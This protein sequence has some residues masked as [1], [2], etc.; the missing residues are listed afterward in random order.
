MSRTTRLLSGAVVGYL[1]QAVAILVGLWLPA[2]MLHH[3]GREAYGSWVIVAKAMG[4]LALLDIGV[5]AIFPRDLAIAVGESRTQERLDPIH[6]IVG[7]TA[8]VVALQTPIVAMGA[9]VAWFYVR[10]SAPQL[11]APYAGM[12]VVM[13]MTFPLRMST[14]L[15]TGVQDFAA[16]GV[17]QLISFC[18]QTTVTVLCVF[19][20][21]EFG[22]LAVGWGAGQCTAYSGATIRVLTR[23]RSYIRF[24]TVKFEWASVVKLFK[25]SIWPSLGQIAHLLVYGSDVLIL[26]L[27]RGAGAVAIYAFT[28]KL[29]QLSEIALQMV[30]QLG[31]PAF[32]ELHG[33]GNLPNFRRAYAA[34]GQGTLLLAGG[35]LTSVVAV[36][37]PFVSWWVGHD[38]YG[39]R[40][41]T[42]L[43]AM[44]TFFRTCNL[45]IYFPAYF[46]GHERSVSIGGVVDTF[47]TVGGRFLLVRWIGPI[48]APIASLIGVVG[49]SIPTCIFVCSRIMK[50]SPLAVIRPFVAVGILVFGAG[51]VAVFGDVYL[52]HFSPLV[53]WL[54]GGAIFFLGYVAL[55]LTLALRLTL[56]DYLRPRL[57]RMRR[58]LPGAG[59][60][61]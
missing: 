60:T 35:V 50:Q 1:N 23:Y 57:A 42:I 39:G 12:L 7:R 16:S 22:A 59:S 43:G 10:G 33:E 48:G 36:N 3:I 37:G 54:V 49:I 25:S 18:V 4:V 51:L 52:R 53:G 24:S 8:R 5:V 13:V 9:V 21:L 45:A 46:A 11:A 20:G 17:I 2:F 55:A 29:S 14:A 26:G 27:F 41:L 61:T 32:G 19:Q 30:L 6:A 47:V 38:N 34:F 40:L 15:L 44:A 28:L 58:F 31:G 56:G